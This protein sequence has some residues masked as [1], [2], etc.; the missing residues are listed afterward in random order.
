MHITRDEI[1]NSSK[2]N[3][4]LRV[5]N[6]CMLGL[7]FTSSIGH[8]SYWV[9]FSRNEWRYPNSNWIKDKLGVF[10]KSCFL[11]TWQ[12]PT[13]KPD[14]FQ[15]IPNIR[16]YS[17]CPLAKEKLGHIPKLFS[18]WRRLNWILSLNQNYFN[19]DE[20]L[21]INVI[22]E[23]WLGLYVTWSKFCCRRNNKL[24]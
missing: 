14:I 21:L 15:K 24:Q 20:I 12:F 10:Q 19:V 7:R 11:G 5:P 22:S 1:Y 16:D 6:F 3:F 17:I 13:Y 23:I 18:F 4:V 2:Y 8:L 9:E